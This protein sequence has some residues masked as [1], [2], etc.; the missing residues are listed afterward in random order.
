MKFSWPWTALQEMLKTMNP[1]LMYDLEKHHPVAY[2][3]LKQYKYQFLYTI[4]QG[5]SGTGV[6]G[7]DLYRTGSE[8]RPDHPA[9]DRIGFYA[10]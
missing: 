5:E 8:Y 7:E 2:K 6:Y 3:R 9:P 4:D 1:Q 10:F